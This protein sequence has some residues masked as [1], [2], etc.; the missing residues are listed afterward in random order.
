METL[1]RLDQYQDNINCPKNV[2][3]PLKICS[4]TG[5]HLHSMVKEKSI[6]LIDLLRI[7]AG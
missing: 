7:W 1:I 3:L 5:R 4:L 6:D 2:E